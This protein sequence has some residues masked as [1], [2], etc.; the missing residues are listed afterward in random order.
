ML[1]TNHER[2]RFTI[3]EVARMVDAGVLGEDEPLEL[4]EGELIVV[5]PQGPEHAERVTRLTMLLAPRYVGRADVRV[6]CPL[7]LDAINQ[8][9]PDLA[10]VHP[11]P[12]RHPRGADVLVVIEISKSSQALDRT[13]VGLYARGGVPIYWRIDLV[14]RRVEEHTHP[15]AAGEYGVTRVYGARDTIALPELGSAELGETVP[16]EALLGPE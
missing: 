10:V 15:T 6:Q 3:D 13:K 5:P 14:A 11:T 16:V 1:A 2:R 9:E 4:I 7:D 8:P 12:G